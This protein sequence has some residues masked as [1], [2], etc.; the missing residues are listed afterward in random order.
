M[1]TTTDLPAAVHARAL[2]ISRARGQS[3][4]SVVAELTARGLASFGEP[5]EVTT[6]EISGF[7]AIRINRPVTAVDVA[8]ILEDE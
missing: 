5:V 2:A 8:E 4:S 6:D 1:R 7:P 3:L